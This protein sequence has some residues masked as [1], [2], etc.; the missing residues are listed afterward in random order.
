MLFEAVNKVKNMSTY[1]E[2]LPRLERSQIQEHTRVPEFVVKKKRERLF[3]HIRP[4]L[5]K[6]ESDIAEYQSSFT[7]DMLADAHA[8]YEAVRSEVDEIER[9]VNEQGLAEEITIIK[10]LCRKKDLL[11]NK[12]RVSDIGI[13]S[14]TQQL[15]AALCSVKDVDTCQFSKEFCGLLSSEVLDGLKLP[16]QKELDSLSK[17][18]DS[19][20]ENGGNL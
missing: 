13:V 4:F 2:Q 15:K 9:K 1:L 12:Q 19:L 6:I 18:C 20:R 3:M 16:S 10:E 7:E 17:M 14:T 5:D 11:L 8:R